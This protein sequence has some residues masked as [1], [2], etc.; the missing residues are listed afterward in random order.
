MS[1][2]AFS[3]ASSPGVA[4]GGEGGA[5]SDLGVNSGEVRADFELLGPGEGIEHRRSGEGGVA[6]GR[7]LRSRADLLAAVLL[8]RSLSRPDS[9]SKST[10]LLCA[11]SW[12]TPETT[13]E[14]A[15]GFM[16]A[17]FKERDDGAC[18]RCDRGEEGGEKARGDV[19]VG[20][21]GRESPKR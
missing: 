16:R 12:D 19:R 10:T 17:W 14:R 2:T 6:T 5:E 18:R 15:G 20:S 9:S 21:P 8:S 1:E 4:K 13:R 7:M 3:L 11:C